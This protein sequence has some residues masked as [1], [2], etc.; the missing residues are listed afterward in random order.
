[1]VR[2]TSV[3]ACTLLFLASCDGES[4]N[5]PEATTMALSHM[6]AGPAEGDPEGSIRLILNDP[7]DRALPTSQCDV[8]LCTSLLELIEGAEESIDFAVYGMRNQEVL[9]DALVRAKARGVQVRGV[10][11][12]DVDGDNYYSGT[13]AMIAALGGHV[14]DDRRA[15]QQLERE[16]LRDERDKKFAADP[17]CERPE[18]FAGYVQCLAYDLGDT[19]LLA[20]HASREPF[21]SSE[22]GNTGKAFNKI[23]HDKFFVVDGHQ[24]WTGST[25]VSDSGTGGYNANLALVLD[26]PTVARWYTQEFEEMYAGKHHQLKTA[27]KALYGQDLVTTVGDAEVQVLFSPQDKAISEGVRPALKAAKRRIDISVF[28]LTS[29]A[30]TKDLI[31]AH[32]RGVAVRVILDATAAKNGYTKHELLRAAGIPVKVEAWGGKMHMKSAIIDDDV[33][34]AGSMNWTSAGEWDNDENTLIIRSAALVQQYDE[35]FAHIWA[36]IPE[37][38]AHENPDPESLDS[39]TACADGFDNDYDQQADG[40]DPGCGPNPPPLPEL[41]PHWTVP[42]DKITCQHPPKG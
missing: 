37:R 36:A 7:S 3:L 30:I 19:C 15:D 32:R 18:G 42:K 25:N 40:E 31:D 4:T 1:M 20:T 12:R 17:P 8:E 38:W 21:G 24:L 39:G 13:D 33:L 34:I 2:P 23:M 11:D 29:K 26:S 16:F 27:S 6:S 28:F 9:L 41:P 5:S 35:F 10:V 14:H 22:D